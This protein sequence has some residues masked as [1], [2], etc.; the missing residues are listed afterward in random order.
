MRFGI[1]FSQHHAL[2]IRPGYPGGGVAQEVGAVLAGW[3]FGGFPVVVLSD[4]VEVPAVLV[5]Q[6]RH[7]PGGIFEGLHLIDSLLL[8]DFNGNAGGV[9]AV[10]CAAVAR[11]PA[12]LSVFKALIHGIGVIHIIMH[13]HL[14]G[15]Q[16]PFGLCV[17]VGQGVGGGVAGVVNGDGGGRHRAVGAAGCA[18]D[19]QRCK[20]LFNFH[21]KDRTF[22]ALTGHKNRF[23]FKLISILPLRASTSRNE[24]VLTARLVLLLCL[25]L[26]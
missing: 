1:D 26:V 12:L 18:V 23:I 13:S 22:L 4:V 11:V 14:H 15:G 8:T 2:E 6:V 24:G 21:D 7:Q 9:A 5:Q 3:V 20:H 16:I 17:G 19:G 25:L 10:W